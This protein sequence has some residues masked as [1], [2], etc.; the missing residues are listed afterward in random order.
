MQEMLKDHEVKII[1]IHAHDIPKII[2][3]T[4]SVQSISS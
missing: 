4:K 2:T 1:G 3:D